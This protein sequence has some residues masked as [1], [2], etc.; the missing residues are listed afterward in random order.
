M[1]SK[2]SF[3][4]LGRRQNRGY[5][6]NDF[7]AS[8]PSHTPRNL[9]LTAVFKNCQVVAQTRKGKM[10]TR[11]IRAQVAVLERRWSPEGSAAKF[12]GQGSAERRPR[13]PWP[14]PAFCP[15]NRFSRPVLH[16]SPLGP[17]SSPRLS[18]RWLTA[19]HSKPVRSA[20][21][22]PGGCTLPPGL[23]VGGRVL[24]RGVAA[25]GPGPRSPP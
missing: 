6:S 3:L 5:N 1:G 16:G 24:R 9:S 7:S 23:A 4:S 21:A 19:G 15:W 11:K 14:R 13:L 17:F 10:H 25:A 8:V 18:P 2:G 22:G 20:P 12:Q